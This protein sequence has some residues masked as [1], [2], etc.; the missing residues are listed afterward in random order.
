MSIHPPNLPT[1][2]SSQS[3]SPLLPEGIVVPLDAF[4]KTESDPKNGI[5][6]DADSQLMQLP[7]EIRTKILS[8]L[9]C[10]DS[11]L[12]IS[13]STEFTCHARMEGHHH[14]KR[15]RLFPAILRVNRKLRSEGIAV[16]YDNNVLSIRANFES[17]NLLLH[18]IHSTYATVSMFDHV[19]FLS[20]IGFDRP[21][22][23]WPLWPP[24]RLFRNFHI[25]VKLQPNIH[26]LRVKATLQELVMTLNQEYPC[27]KPRTVILI[28]EEEILNL[29]TRPRPNPLDVCEDSEACSDCKAFKTEKAETA[30]RVL[31][32]FKA[33]KNVSDVSILSPIANADE[34]ISQIK[35][36]NKGP[37]LFPL[38]WALLSYIQRLPDDPYSVELGW[39]QEKSCSE[40]FEWTCNDPDDLASEGVLSEGEDYHEFSM[41]EE[42]GHWRCPL[43]L[44]NRMRMLRRAMD[45]GD[46][47]AFRWWRGDILSLIY[48]VMKD[49]Q[50]SLVYMF[51]GG[52]R[53]PEDEESGI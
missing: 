3:I 27:T 11:P 18:R 44:R 41:S 14:A 39:N 51:E 8:F 4:G 31:A 48:L 1:Q 35:D 36:P 26:P 10:S 5:N 23:M 34:L 30:A 47:D 6:H 15:Y 43:W 42:T 20:E 16:M 28:C 21:I 40:G 19:A 2:F 37:D 52:R 49:L 50:D 9:L 32:P 45:K 53:P 46:E 22:R 13:C 7:S 17:A 29:C 33:L 38:Y 24:Q 25:H 12:Q